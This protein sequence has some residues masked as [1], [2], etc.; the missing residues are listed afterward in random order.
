MTILNIFAVYDRKAQYY[1]P[2]FTDQYEANAIRTFTEAV[3]TSETPLS[4]YPADFDLVHLGTMDVRDGDL[5]ALG[6]ANILVNG[7][8]A[9]ESAQRERARYQAILHRDSAV[10]P[11]SAP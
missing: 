10:E 8:V 6:H 7:L 9:L 1:L 5:V 11:S 2:P 4:Q 3:M